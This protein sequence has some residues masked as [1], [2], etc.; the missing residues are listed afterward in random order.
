M[1]KLSGAVTGAARVAGPLEARKDV[2]QP[3]AA[4]KAASSGSGSSVDLSGLAAQLLSGEAPVDQTRIEE[5]RAAIAE[6]RYPVDAEAVA[7][8]MVEFELG[9]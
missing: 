9:E 4:D 5:I 3:A 8:K 2:P 1:D 6:G 7:A